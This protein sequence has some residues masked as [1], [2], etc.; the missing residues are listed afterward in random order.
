MTIEEKWKIEESRAFMTKLDGMLFRIKYLFPSGNLIK[1]Y[2]KKLERK[3]K[4]E[5]LMEKKKLE[6]KR[7]KELKEKAEQ[8]KSS[9][10]A[11]SRGKLV[12]L[13]GDSSHMSRKLGDGSHM[14]QRLGDY[15]HKSDCSPM[16]TPGSPYKYHLRRFSSKD[17]TKNL[18]PSE[19]RNLTNL[20]PED[21]TQQRKSLFGG[22]LKI[23]KCDTD[24]PKR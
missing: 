3:K 17:P 1:D 7:Q 22:N 4:K 24:S 23:V 11:S 16:H 19:R 6:I 5:E 21:E 13:L 12:N 15:S 9:D 20:S 8:E 18:T 14:S 2:N 10:E